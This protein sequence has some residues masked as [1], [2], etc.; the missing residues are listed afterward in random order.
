MIGKGGY[1]AEWYTHEWVRVQVRIR[2]MHSGCIHKVCGVMTTGP[3]YEVGIGLGWSWQLTGV[4]KIHSRLKRG[5][6]IG[7]YGRCS[8]YNS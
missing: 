6:G 1:A 7:Y 2:A 4:T 8:I 5:D 3:G